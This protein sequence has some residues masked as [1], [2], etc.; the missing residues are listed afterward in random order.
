MKVNYPK[1][2]EWA[3]LLLLAAWMLFPGLTGLFCLL[4]LVV[5]ITGIVKKELT[6]KFNIILLGVS[7]FLPFYSLYAMNAIDGKLI[8]KCNDTEDCAVGFH[9]PGYASGHGRFPEKHD[10]GCTDMVSR[11]LGDNPDVNPVEFEDR[12]PNKTSKIALI[13]DPKRDYH[14]LRQDSNGMWSHKPG[15]MEVTTLDASDRPILRPDRALFSYKNKKD[16]LK[17]T[18]FCGYYCVPRGKPLYLMA[19]P[20]QDGGKL[21]MQKG[22][23]IWPNSLDVSSVFR[24]SSRYRQTRR[25]SRGVSRRLRD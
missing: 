15:A 3:L 19:D 24:K 1:V 17:Y 4:F 23:E 10:K 18:K 9:Q 12:C 22:G 16:P 13:V 7:L 20:R 5:V 2:Y 8:K 21:I 11:M 25:K 14:F 6:F